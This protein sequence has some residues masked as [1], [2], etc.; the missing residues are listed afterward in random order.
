[1]V[2]GENCNIVNDSHKCSVQICTS[3]MEEI[4]SMTRILV[5]NKVITHMQMR[6]DGSIKLP[7]RLF[8]QVCREQS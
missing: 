8:L 1:M 3:Y 2:S 5:N 6:P 4:P 7:Y